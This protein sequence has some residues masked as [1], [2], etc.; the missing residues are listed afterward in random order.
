MQHMSNDTMPDA[1]IDESPI[2]AAA[3]ALLD[4]RVKR[5]GDRERD[6]D[7]ERNK[8]AL[9]AVLASGRFDDTDVLSALTRLMVQ[10]RLSPDTGRRLE[11]HPQLMEVYHERF[12]RAVRESA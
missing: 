6:H 11:T 1:G 9:E 8:Q 4:E 5:G 12:A 3:E 7:P 2:V 10:G